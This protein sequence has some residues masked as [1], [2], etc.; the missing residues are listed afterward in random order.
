MADQGDA[1]ACYKVGLC[2]ENGDGVPRDYIMAVAY[3][4]HAESKGHVKA[5]VNLALCYQ[6]GN[7]VEQNT[8]AA[9]KLLREAQKLNDDSAAIFLENILDKEE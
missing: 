4:S 8:T 9:I 2:Y 1:E 3:Y 6:L 5:K 7:G